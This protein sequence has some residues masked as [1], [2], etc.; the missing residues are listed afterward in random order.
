MQILNGPSVCWSGVQMQGW[1]YEVGGALFAGL[2]VGL[3]WCLL[4]A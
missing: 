4:I 1:Q 3:D 2:G